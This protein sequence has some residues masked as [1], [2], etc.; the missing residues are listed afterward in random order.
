MVKI[1]SSEDKQ[2]I[3]QTSREEEAKGKRG[4]SKDPEPGRLQDSGQQPRSQRRWTEATKVLKG[5]YFLPRNAVSVRWNNDVF[6]T[7]A[8]HEPFLADDQQEYFRVRKK[9]K[10]VSGTQVLGANGADWTAQDG[11]SGRGFPQEG[12]LREGK[13]PR[14]LEG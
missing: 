7:Q 8:S 13:A 12:N 14:G 9:E 1:Q 10:S 2:R 3:L 11:S 6:Q 4:P 5:N